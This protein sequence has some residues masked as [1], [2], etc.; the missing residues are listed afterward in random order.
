M[1]RI[2]KFSSSREAAYL[3]YKQADLA[4][5]KAAIRPPPGVAVSRASL[6][7]RVMRWLAQRG[8]RVVPAGTG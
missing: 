7:E 2:D 8:R 3:Q 6:R 4:W 1:D 5:R